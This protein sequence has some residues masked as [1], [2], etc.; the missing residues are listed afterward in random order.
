MP[1]PTQHF[2]HWTLPLNVHLHYKGR[3]YVYRLH[4]AILDRPLS[5]AA[6][7][8]VQ[9][10]D[11]IGR[12]IQGLLFL[13]CWW[14][15]G[16]ICIFWPLLRT[17]WLGGLVGTPSPPSNQSGLSP[18]PSPLGYVL[19]PM[20]RMNQRPA[21]EVSTPQTHREETLQR[22]QGENRLLRRLAG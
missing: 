21:Y 17:R 19:H 3:N 14:C 13:A 20:Q 12:R 7:K 18:P 1:L 2:F 10:P 4:T 8:E 6:T 9:G 15:M 5:S 22:D 11:T 16:A